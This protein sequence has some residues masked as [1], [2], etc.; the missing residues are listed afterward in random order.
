MLITEFLDKLSTQPENIEFT[1]TMAVI[2]LHYSFTD[3]SFVNGLQINAAGEN[4][5][6]CKLFSFAQLQNLNESK[7]LACFGRYYREDVLDFPNAQDHQ[8][9]RQFMINGWKGLH[10]ESQALNQK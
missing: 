6:S 5:G 4:S 3:T 7:T 2:E 8:N 10:F 1:D 9:I